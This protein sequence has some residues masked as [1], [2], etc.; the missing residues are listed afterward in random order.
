MQHCDE[1]GLA[2]IQ[3]QM[4]PD[5][6]NPDLRTKPRKPRGER[7]VGGGKEGGEKRSKKGADNKPDNRLKHVY[8]G[9][10]DAFIMMQKDSLPPAV[11]S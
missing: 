4:Q 7:R 3:P 11:T 5:D 9:V 8:L 10:S 2:F 6:D 1:R